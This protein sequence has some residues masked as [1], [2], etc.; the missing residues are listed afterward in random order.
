MRCFLGGQVILERLFPRL[1]VVL[2][3]GLASALAPSSFATGDPAKDDP[4]AGKQRASF[5]LTPAHT[6]MRIDGVLDDPAWASATVIP[7][8]HEWLP[9][10]NTEPPVRTE[11]LVTLDHENLYVGFRAFDPDPSQIRLH[12]ADRDFPFLDD[13]V[14][15]LIDTF[16]SQRRAYLFKVNPL[17]VQFDATVSDVDDS[18]DSS[19]DAIWN[20]AGRLTTDGYVVEMAIPFRQLR[21]APSQQKQT[22]GFLAT[23]TYPRSVVHELR[24]TANDRSQS[25]L[26]CQFDSLEGL[27]GLEVGYNLEVVP[28]IT[29][30]RTDQ[31]TTL[32]S[33]IESGEEDVEAG[34]SVRWGL[35]PSLTLNA[36]INPDFSQVEADVAQLDVNERFALFFPE[37]RPFFLEGADFFSTPIRAVFTRTIA[38]PEVGVKLTGKKDKNVFGVQFAR[39][40]IT[41]LI[42]PGFES[43]GFSSV[44]QDVDSA[45]L[46]YRRDVGRTST[47][48]FLYS[49]R[50]G[51]DYRNHVYGVDGAYRLARSNTLRFQLLNATTAYPDA[52]AEDNGQQLGSF[53]GHAWQVDFAHATRDWRWRVNASETD[54]DFRADGG[55]VTRVAVQQA[56]FDASRFFWPEED[57]WFSRLQA[58]IN[59]ILIQTQDSELVEQGLNIEF[60]YE[61]PKQSRIAVGI[62]PNEEAFR[63]Q[64]FKNVRGDIRASFRPSGDLRV[65]LFVRGGEIVDFTNV[66]KSDFRRIEP[67]MEFNLGRRISGELSY[68]WEEFD[69]EGQKFLEANL[70]QT[71]LRYHFNVRTFVRAIFQYR[72]VE[73]D[74]ALYNPGIQLPPKQE[75]LFSQLLFSYK[76]NP[77]TVLLAGYSDTAQGNES[78]DLTQRSRSFF[79]KIGYAWLR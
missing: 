31:R 7:L 10:D 28:T 59:G 22:W 18:E 70:A 50:Q 19:W 42:F 29:A 13:T 65:E 49:G 8:T 44:D 30:T 26:V 77:Q 56:F 23:R 21:F 24:S 1:C 34:L 33:P 45:I 35:T 73:R 75:E 16:D 17:G 40:N 37:K 67:S 46:R 4:A 57:S 64:S 6:P 69:F 51:D 74:L 5:S 47:L 36:A 66:R 32:T 53:S 3:F 41:N 39:D 12:L 78:I 27:E 38:N 71:T 54:E 76:L 61:G 68:T 60:F 25:C 72:D 14:G 48:G 58:R 15:F 55:F 20:S 63:G 79:L 9:G 52:V 43:S 62:R 2:A 11:C